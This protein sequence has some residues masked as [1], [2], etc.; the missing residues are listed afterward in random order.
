MKV[1]EASPVE[2]EEASWRSIARQMAVKYERLAADHERLEAKYERCKEQVFKKRAER[3]WAWIASDICRGE[4]QASYN[5]NVLLRDEIKRLGGWI[6]EPPSPYIVTT[7]PPRHPEAKAEWELWKQKRE[8]VA[9]IK[10]LRARGS[11]ERGE[12]RVSGNREV[13]LTGGSGSARCESGS[14]SKGKVGGDASGSKSGD[15]DREVVVLKRK[16]D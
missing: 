5:W 1:K 11:K 10:V 9:L 4:W 16:R 7:L 2:E 12:R 13:D 14:E 8:D 6:P 3:N 15:R